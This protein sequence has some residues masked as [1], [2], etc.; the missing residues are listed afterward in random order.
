M[1]SS[2]SFLITI[3]LI[4]FLVISHPAL[5]HIL[6]GDIAPVG[7]PDGQVN[8]G[9]ALIALRIALNLEPGHPT[10][11]E[12]SYGDVAPLDANNMP[13]PDGQITVGDALLI[14]RVALGQITLPLIETTKHMTK[15]II[16]DEET[17]LDFVISIPEGLDISKEQL[18]YLAWVE[19]ELGEE[20]YTYS[21][22]LRQNA[23][24]SGIEYDGYIDVKVVLVRDW[25][26]QCMRYFTNNFDSSIDPFYYRSDL[27]VV[28]VID[29]VLSEL[30]NLG[31]KAN[32]KVVLCGF[33]GGAV[34]AE[35]FS[36][37]WP[38]RVMAVVGGSSGGYITW[39]DTHK[40]GIP[41]EM[42]MGLYDY[43]EKMGKPFN[44]QAYS[45]IIK[46]FQIGSLDNMC[47]FHK[48][49]N[50]NDEELNNQNSSL[51]I[52]RSMGETDPIRIYNQIEFNRSQG[53]DN[54]YFKIYKNVLHDDC[55]EM[56]E[57]IM[58]EI[59]EHRENTDLS[60]YS[61][62]EE[63]VKEYTSEKHIQMM[64]HGYYSQNSY[65]VRYYSYGFEEK[66]PLHE[67]I[68]FNDKAFETAIR[69]FCEIEDEKQI[70]YGDIYRYRKLELINKGINDLSGIKYFHNLRELFLINNNISDISELEEL[71]H[72]GVLN[73]SCNQ[74]SD[75]SSLSHLKELIYLFLDYTGVEDLTFLD[76][77]NEL[78]VLTFTGNNLDDYAPLAKYTD[79]VCL[80]LGGNP[81]K[82]FDVLN[83]FRYLNMQKES[84]LCNVYGFFGTEVQENENL[85]DDEMK[86][87]FKDTN[88]EKAV[89]DY[90]GKKEGIIYY[91]DIKN[92]E[93]FSANGYSIKNIDGIQYMNN[94]VDVELMD[95]AITDISH[96]EQLTKLQ[97]LMIDNNDLS[98]TDLSGLENLKELRYL[99]LNGTNI[100]EI[101]FVKN[102]V[103]LKELHVQWNNIEDVEPILHLTYLEHAYLGGNPIKN[104]EVLN[105]MKGIHMN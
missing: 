58:Q 93:N 49:M 27:K 71:E 74:I 42:F 61:S 97:S 83:N 51:N 75:F 96:I 79:A 65:D 14:L 23:L 20:H 105:G 50:D 32:E 89:R 84:T 85:Y 103:N 81:G 48:T 69:E 4:I 35:R 11:D 47:S 99:Y 26:H 5:S 78:V 68:L 22:E 104:I 6:L 63:E 43:E 30:K 98:M 62:S 100:N 90:I 8:V 54:Y 82:N 36:L 15:Y 40:D 53:I 41:L 10:A 21:K 46:F 39:L 86:V 1:K 2:N 25:E 28:S 95:N 19:T 77:L 7:N 87:T 31:I 16:G 102:I 44:K 34:F 67:V 52:A 37:M 59:L 64:Y 76:P 60:E 18:I 94:L 70:T 56:T 24:G 55:G 13:N 17:G 9:D 80:N 45:N 29:K 12:L 72:L 38:E 92:L 73:L 91:K 57:K 88:L 66:Y 33:S 3:F 101:D